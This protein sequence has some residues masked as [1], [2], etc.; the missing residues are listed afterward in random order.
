MYTP[1]FRMS[2]DGA[3]VLRRNEIEVHGER[4]IADFQRDALFN[5]QPL[6]F[7]RFIELYLGLNLDIMNLSSNGVVMGMFV[8]GETDSLPFFNPV[9]NVAEYTHVD[10]NTVIIDQ[11][12]ISDTKKEHLLQFT[13]GH[14][15]SHGIYHRQFLLLKTHQHTPSGVDKPGPVMLCRKGS[16]G[17]AQEENGQL[18]WTP[19]K[20]IEWQANKLASCLLM[21][22]PAVRY[23]FEANGRTGGHSEQVIKSIGD[24]VRE[25]NVSREAAAYR[26]VD[27]KLADREEVRHYLTASS[28]TGFAGCAW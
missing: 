7:M 4:L 2:K 12:L 19:E 14:E 17:P 13:L 25:C 24:L 10:A 3:P 1:V 9:R 23:L 22:R 5:V 27:L 28:L 18:I 15:A 11:R 21:P 20:R 16:V 26:L 6:D 8:A